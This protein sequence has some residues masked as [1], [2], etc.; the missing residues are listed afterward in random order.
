M[1][2]IQRSECGGF[3]L[4]LHNV[5]DKGNAHRDD[6]EEEAHPD[7]YSEEEEEYRPDESDEDQEVEEEEGPGPPGIFQ[8]DEC[9]HR[10]DCG[11]G[12]KHKGEWEYLPLLEEEHG[13]QY[14][15]GKDQE[16]DYPRP[17]FACLTQKL[18]S[19]RIELPL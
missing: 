12:G 5:E 6:E 17:L 4:G 8:V 1:N 14:G 18:H 7:V 2:F 11:K 19:G 3:G 16:E 10:V 15:N 13:P 9:H